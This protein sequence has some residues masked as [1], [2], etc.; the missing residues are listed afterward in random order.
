M[1]M[2]TDTPERIML[3]L[4]RHGPLTAV[5][6]GTIVGKK[7]GSVSVLMK[8]MIANGWIERRKESGSYLYFLVDK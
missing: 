4:K 8:K 5:Q 6:L 2:R 1:P 3:A 7:K